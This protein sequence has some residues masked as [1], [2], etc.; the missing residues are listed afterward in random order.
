MIKKDIH[1]FADVSFKTQVRVMEGYRDKE[2]D[3]I[4]QRTIKSLDI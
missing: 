2:S 1:K 4:R 3:K